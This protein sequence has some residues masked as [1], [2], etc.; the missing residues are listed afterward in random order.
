[1]TLFGH[2]PSLLRSQESSEVVLEAHSSAADAGSEA[3]QPQLQQ[4]AAEGAAESSAPGGQATAQA[5][6]LRSEEEK[7]AILQEAVRD[8]ERP[9]HFV[10]NV[11]WLQNVIGIAVDQIFGD[12]RTPLSCYFFWPQEEAWEMTREYLEHEHDWI[13]EE[14]KIEL[15]NEFTRLIAYWESEGATVEAARSM[16]KL[17]RFHG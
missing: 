4:A 12:L 10:L 3:E 15:L 7:E 8:P 13:T 14:D 1:M 6:E 16:F 17:C 9:Y 5:Q 11:L 2:P